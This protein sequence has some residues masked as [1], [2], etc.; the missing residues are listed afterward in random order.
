VTPA[1]ESFA[2]YTAKLLRF[3]L[4]GAT[5]KAI[6]FPLSP[7]TSEPVTRER[8]SSV[9]PAFAI[10]LLTAAAAA[11]P[12]DLAFIRGSWEGGPAGM[13]FQERWTEEAG[14]LMLGVSRTLR[15]GRAVAFEFLR[16]EF[17]DDGVFYVAQPGGAPKTEFKLTA[18]NSNSATFENPGHDHPKLIRYSLQS[19]GALKA[20]LEGAEGKQAFVFRPAP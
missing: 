8:V 2:T 4:D 20:E 14:G 6:R 11:G 10:A 17:R 16:I 3:A 18:F 7:H 19:D 13:K 15:G 5:G 1:P 9:L 12:A